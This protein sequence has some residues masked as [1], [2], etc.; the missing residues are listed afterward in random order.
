MKVR[1][2]P[3]K[4]NSGLE[5]QMPVDH[6]GSHYFAARATDSAYLRT[7]ARSQGAVEHEKFLFYR[8][9]GNFNVPLQ[10]L[11]KSDRELVL[12]NTS[13]ARLAHLFVLSVHDQEGRLAQL[14]AIGGGEQRSVR[15]ESEPVARAELMAQIGRVMTEALVSEGLYPREAAAMVATWQ[16]SWFAED[17]VRV[18]YVLPRAWTDARL[19]LTLTPAPRALVRVMVGRSEVLTP[20]LET[21]LT[22]TLNAAH[23]GDQA[24]RQE[25][26]ARLKHLGRFADPALRLVQLHGS[27]DAA[28]V[29]Y[30][31]LHESD[32]VKAATFQLL[33]EPASLKI[34]NFN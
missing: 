29:G 14:D 33:L 25:A 24:A 31:L 7:G 28:K 22:R 2:F 23:Q 20:A 30:Q 26:S 16:D 27:V 21:S 5:A 11:S 4:E 6:S 34:A 10:V 32:P 19:P 3:A 9:V 1:I 12:T 13:A 17:G 15:L 18:L 8:G